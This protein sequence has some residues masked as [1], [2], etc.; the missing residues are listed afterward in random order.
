M[1]GFGTHLTCTCTHFQIKNAHFYLHCRLYYQHWVG[2]GCWHCL[3]FHASSC[4]FS[5]ES[6]LSHHAIF[7]HKIE[8]LMQGLSWREWPLQT[9]Q[10]FLWEF[11]HTTKKQKLNALLMFLRMN[12]LF[13]SERRNIQLGMLLV[14]NLVLVLYCTSYYHITCS[15][16]LYFF[17]LFTLP[18]PSL[19]M[20]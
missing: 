10:L 3:P 11:S 14:P 17:G 18:V 20:G 8:W 12:I 7:A 4:F 9:K 13:Q 1:F 19:I 5:S 6:H 2:G 16:Q 15:N